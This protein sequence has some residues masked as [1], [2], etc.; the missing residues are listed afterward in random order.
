MKTPRRFY[1]LALLALIGLGFSISLTQHFFEVR[2]GTAGF[3]SFCNV[4]SQMNCDVVA[5]SS[6]AELFPGFPLAI[7]AAGYFTLLFALSLFGF[8]GTWRRESLRGL[9]LMTGGGILLC[10]SYF[11]VMSQV[12]KTFCLFCL[13]ID[14]TIL[15]ALGV[16]LSLKP[17]ST[18]KAPLDF[19]KWKTFLLV[20]LGC[21]LVPTVFLKA[22]DTVALKSSDIEEYFQSALNTPVLAVNTGPELPSIGLPNAPVTIVKFAD[23]QCP[24]CKL[25]AHTLHSLLNRFPDR[26]RVVFRN[27]PLDPSCNRKIERP[28]HAAACEAARVAICAGKQGKFA[29]VY[30][31]LFDN[32]EHL[33]PRKPTE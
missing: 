33:A 10:L 13:G 4:S 15:V 7:F 18:K 11:F 32:Q 26:V 28:M 21:F 23:F 22:F 8:S 3:R 27:Y 14:V 25:G 12:L 9:F 30:E 6:Y 20:S 17:E 29:P 5:A 31:L 16:V 1:T 2:G 24:S 19:A